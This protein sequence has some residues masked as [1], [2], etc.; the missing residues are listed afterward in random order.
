MALPPLSAACTALLDGC[1]V[2]ASV[3]LA[4][5]L[6]ADWRLQLHEALPGGCC[7]IIYAGTDADG[8]E[9]VLKIPVRGEEMTTGHHAAK[10]FS[11]CGGVEILRDDGDS[12]ALLMPRLRP[13]VSLAAVHGLDIEA[14]K[15]TAAITRRLHTAELAVDA[16]LE[17]YLAEPHSP[18]KPPSS[19]YA[20]E[21]PTLELQER[22]LR[23]QREMVLLHGD[24]HHYNVLKDGDVWLAIDPKGIVGDPAF[25]PSSFLRNPYD[26]FPD[27]WDFIGLQRERILA[28]ARLLKLSPWRIWAWGLVANVLGCSWNDMSPEESRHFLAIQA[29]WELRDEFTGE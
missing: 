14:A 28:F 24:L 9:I 20:M 11:S 3:S 27:R 26:L 2:A 19:A 8:R 16:R 6:A 23:T 18:A 4:E 25:E 13:G 21:G 15:I 1:D 7:S 22:L 5:H 10:A 17:E 29:L 12:G